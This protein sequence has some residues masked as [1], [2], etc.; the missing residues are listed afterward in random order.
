MLVD[1]GR[2]DLGK[3]SKFNSVKVISYMDNFKV[4]ESYSYSECGK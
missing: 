1:L 4:L 2:N 3:I